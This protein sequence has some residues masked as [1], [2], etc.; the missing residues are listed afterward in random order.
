[1]TLRS[2]FTIF[3]LRK[4][5]VVFP[6]YLIL[7]YSR[8]WISHIWIFSGNCRMQLGEKLA[9]SFT[10]FTFT[11]YLVFEKF[12]EVMKNIV[13]NRYKYYNMMQELRTII[14]YSL[15]STPRMLMNPAPPSPS[16]SVCLL[17]SPSFSLS[18]PPFLSLFNN[19]IPRI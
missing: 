8:Y 12:I 11:E 1:M 2:E 19:S 7:E 3:M 5:T 4:H 9:K 14:V 16:P 13:Y 18:H 10:S 17:N 15:Q 6:Q